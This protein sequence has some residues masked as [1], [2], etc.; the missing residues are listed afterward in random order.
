MAP[1][2]RKPVPGR[3][4]YFYPT[5]E[6]SDMKV[7]SKILIGYEDPRQ[8]KNL[9]EQL[10]FQD[11]ECVK[12]ETGSDALHYLRTWKPDFALLDLLLR[13]YNAMQI[14]G[15]MS[16]ENLLGPNGTKVFVTSTHGSAANIQEAMRRGAVDYLVKPFAV[17]D[18]IRRLGFHSRRMR[19][20]GEVAVGTEGEKSA[21][22]FLNLTE[23]I[24]RQAQS[25]SSQHDL[26]LKLS[27][28]AAM[29]VHA[30]RCSFIEC[31]LTQGQ[32]VVRASNDNPNLMHHVLDLHKYP[33]VVHVINTENMV[34]LD[35]VLKDPTMAQMKSAFQTLDFNAMVVVPVRLRHRI[36][37]VLSARMPRE[38]ESLTDAE[39]RL[40]HI[41]GLAAGLGLANLRAPLKMVRS[42]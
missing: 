34:V 2:K 8:A 11:F 6:L 5:A 9:I 26:L 28:M 25:P 29:A 31:S 23:I 10:P 38:R 42:A 3:G 41:V 27:Q 30:R 14:L 33:E 12:A 36:W 15:V 13:E 20:L 37:G 7:K 19:I 22:L 32:G 40:L 17:E 39:I 16:R 1:A 18:F 35:N 24:L 21:N 4:Q